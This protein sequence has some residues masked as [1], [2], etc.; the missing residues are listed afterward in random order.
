MLGLDLQQELDS[1]N[2]K[3]FNTQTGTYE[4]KKNLKPRFNLI[5][6]WKSPQKGFPGLI[7][8]YPYWCLI[9]LSELLEILSF[10]VIWIDFILRVCDVYGETWSSTIFF[11]T[12]IFLLLTLVVR[13]VVKKFP[14]P[15]IAVQRFTLTDYWDAILIITPIILNI[16]LITTG[17]K[18]SIYIEVFSIFR[19]YRVLIIIP[20]VYQ[21]M[22]I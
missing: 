20:G 7:P 11:Y 9:K 19:I 16:Y 4:T 1:S 18:N 14:Y 13:I 22:V 3:E 12:N 6:W 10:V 8:E 2:D 21:I 5:Q 15:P 17:P